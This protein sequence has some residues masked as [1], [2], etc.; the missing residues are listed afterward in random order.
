MI[1][2]QARDPNLTDEY[3]DV[4]GGCSGE[5]SGWRRYDEPNVGGCGKETCEGPRRQP[6]PEPSRDTR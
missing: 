4:T 2:A 5:C 6:Q 3:L 1:Q